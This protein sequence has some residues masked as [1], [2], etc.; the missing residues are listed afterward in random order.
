MR[1]TAGS[2][3]SDERLGSRIARFGPNTTYTN[4]SGDMFTIARCT[5][6]PRSA[7][8]SRSWVSRAA[9]RAG[10]RLQACGRASSGH[11]RRSIAR[12]HRLGCAWFRNRTV[13]LSWMEVFRARH[14]RS[15]RRPAH[16][17]SSFNRRAHRRLGPDASDLRN[18]S[19]ARRHGR[20][21]RSRYECVGWTC[22]GTVVI[23]SIFS[24]SMRSIHHSQ[25]AR[26][27][28]RER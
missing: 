5:T 10:D 22:V 28:R 13:D 1:E 23:S 17:A 18:R 19:E 9:N 27:S 12:E 26:S 7:I 11:G 21:S 8:R 24:R 14:G 16:W 25:P 6:S 2:C 4:R 3:P 20:R 15:A